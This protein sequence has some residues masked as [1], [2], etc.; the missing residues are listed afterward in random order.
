MNP[1]RLL[2]KTYEPHLNLEPYLYDCVAEHK[3][4]ISAEHGLGFKKRNFI[5][6]SKTESAVRV[7][8]QMKRVMDPNRQDI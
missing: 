6:H 3:G 5:Y 1:L 7:M 2:D 8:S 4:S